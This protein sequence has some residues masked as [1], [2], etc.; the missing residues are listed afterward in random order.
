MELSIHGDN[1]GLFNKNINMTL[2]P[3]VGLVIMLIIKYANILTHNRFL[4]LSFQHILYHLP[5]FL[6]QKH[7]HELGF[8]N[9]PGHCGGTSQVFF[10]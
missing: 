3:K 1:F 6:H 10:G 2:P 9:F 5:D 8:F 4:S 7:T